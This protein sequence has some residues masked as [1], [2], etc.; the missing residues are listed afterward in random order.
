MERN[1]FVLLQELLESVRKFQQDAKEALEEETP[2][3]EKVQ[4]LLDIGNSMDVE[5]PEIPNLK[6]V[7]YWLCFVID[8]S[9]PIV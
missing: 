7:G 3:S 4:N 6:Q 9:S 2:D 5:L 1:H 8:Q